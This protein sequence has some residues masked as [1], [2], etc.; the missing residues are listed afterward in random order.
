MTIDEFISEIE[1]TEPPA[2][3]DK[4]DQ[5][6]REIGATLPLDYRDFLLR[7]NGGSVGGALWYSE[8]TSDGVKADA[9]VHHVGGFR[10][11]SYFSLVQNR[12]CYSGRIPMELLWIM[13]D[14]FGNAICL[15][16][17]RAY[18][19]RIYFWDHEQEPDR[20][21]WDGQFETAGNI[22]LIANSFTD[23]VAGLKAN[24]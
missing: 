15:G 5:L 17:A 7:S 18:R 9:G 21:D 16:I 3:M 24:E 20:A 6:E 8:I 13:D 22:F 11:Q 12:E 2:P 10:E 14:P 4:L 23:F 19:G 1:S